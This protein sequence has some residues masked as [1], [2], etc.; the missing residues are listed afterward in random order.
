MARINH[1]SI[2][3]QAAEVDTATVRATRVFGIDDTVIEFVESTKS[4]IV[5]S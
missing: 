4:G 1:I 3:G 2:L 5:G